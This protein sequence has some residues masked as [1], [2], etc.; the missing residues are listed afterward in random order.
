MSLNLILLRWLWQ[1]NAWWTSKKKENF[2]Y[3]YLNNCC[4]HSIQIRSVGLNIQVKF[5]IWF[6]SDEYWQLAF[7]MLENCEKF[8]FHSLTFEGM[9]ILSWYFIWLSLILVAVW[10]ILTELCLLNLLKEGKL[11]NFHIFIKLIFRKGLMY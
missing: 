7:L 1:S 2:F 9:H 11:F 8:C 3:P 6:R 10:W 5:E 4:T